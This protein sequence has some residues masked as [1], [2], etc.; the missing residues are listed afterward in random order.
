M[1]RKDREVTDRQRIQEIIR[2][3]YCCRIGFIDNGF[4]YIV[5]MN[6]GERIEGEK[7]VFY[8]HCA[9]EGRKIDLIRQN[10]RVGF[11]MDCHA[12]L[13]SGE[14]ACDY[15]STFQSI[16]GTGVLEIVTSVGEKIQGLNALMQHATRLD[17]LMEEASL[18]KDSI[19]ASSA[20]GR[21]SYSSKMLEVTCV[22]KLTVE[23]LSG[24]EKQF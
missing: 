7:I 2:S 19:H 10:P 1:R 8:F 3:C 24:K 16:I 20:D 23:E 14:I 18:P 6:F 13:I 4:V 11:E 17:C 21:W 22:L 9:K 15:S 5:P 12:N